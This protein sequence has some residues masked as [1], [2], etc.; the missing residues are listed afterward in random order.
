MKEEKIKIDKYFLKLILDKVANLQTEIEKLKSEPKVSLT[1]T[2]FKA[3]MFKTA[4]EDLQKAGENG[5]PIFHNSSGMPLTT[6]QCCICVGHCD[7]KVGHV[8]CPAHFEKINHSGP[9]S[10]SSPIV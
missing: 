9:I 7:C 4:A 8:F 2:E 6:K 1:T 3:L 5:T 10:P